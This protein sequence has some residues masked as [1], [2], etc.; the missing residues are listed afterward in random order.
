MIFA[1]KEHLENSAA[2]L[3][4]EAPL[5]S[6]PSGSSGK[7]DLHHEPD[8]KSRWAPSYLTPAE[9]TGGRIGREEEGIGTRQ[10]FDFIVVTMGSEFKSWFDGSP[11]CVRWRQYF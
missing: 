11:G 7:P 8:P 10:Q 2:F 1:A 5:E 4:T 6:Q 9:D 3:S